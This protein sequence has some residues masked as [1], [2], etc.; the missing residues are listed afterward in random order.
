MNLTEKPAAVQPPRGLV[1]GICLLLAIVTLA[2]FGQTL[3]HDFIN[4]D[5]NDY[6]YQ[7]PVVARGLTLKG[8][9]WAF[10]VHA[11]NWHPLTWI[12]HMVDCQLYGLHP[13]GHHLTNVILHAATA[14]LLFLV[15]RQMT[16]ALW[17]SA[18]VAAV[19]AVHPL[20]AESVAW[21][22]ERKDVLSG[23]FFMLTVAVYI[24]YVRRP[25]CWRRYGLVLLL[26]AMGLMCK[27]MLVTLPL[28]LLL[29]DCWPLQRTEST[30]ELLLEKL[31]LLALSG[32]ACV[33]TLFAQSG[34][35]G[36]IAAYSPAM[37]MGNAVLSVFIYLRQMFYPAELAIFYPYP[38]QGLPP[39][40]IV[41]AVIVVAAVSALVFW[42]RKLK[43][44]LWVGWLWYLLMLLPVL[45][46]IQMGRQ[47]HADRYTYLPQIGLYLAVTWLAAE[48]SLKWR[49]SRVLTGGIMVAVILV[50]IGFAWKQTSYWKNGETIWARAIACTKD[51]DAA[52]FNLG[53]VYLLNGRVDDAI[54]EFRSA[55]QI[56]PHV[57]EAE[58]NLGSAYLQKGDA[59][60][61]VS[62]FQSALKIN[63]HFEQAQFSLGNICLQSH[64][65]RE[66]IPHYKAALQMNPDNPVCHLN[67]GIA[68][69][70]TGHEEEAIEQFRKSLQLDPGNAQ[71][72]NNLGNAL[73][74]TGQL[75]EA[76]AHFQ[77]AL[78][79]RADYQK[80]SV[81]LH[82]ALARKEAL[83][84][85]A[86]AEKTPGK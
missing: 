15:V 47:A 40:E 86:P 60:D 51:N 73:M 25:R 68:I 67:L 81:N 50:L 71:T 5:D 49:M 44:W 64:Q 62:H 1:A 85:S 20:R 27:P 26:F 31:P 59:A 83:N 53:A 39:G 61:A 24:C 54:A 70:Q 34:N 43:P 12:S 46:I 23:L 78:Q 80:A 22:A 38:Y 41:I 7:N 33:A 48:W 3:T 30:R 63:P 18:F 76:I 17:R 72:E 6:V 35:I 52:H 16:G 32:A 58:Y 13:G 21:V 14:I 77:K 37:R 8:I 19:F 42:K 36:S 75:D 11:V 28:V 10:G 9:A 84:P 56:N 2:V 66:A 55:L 65:W 57:A 69:E 29:L 4:F 45:G 82:N 79:I 74:Q